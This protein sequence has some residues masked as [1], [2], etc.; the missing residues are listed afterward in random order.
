[1]ITLEISL[2]FT[3][4]ELGCELSSLFKGDILFLQIAVMLEMKN[5]NRSKRKHRI[6]EF[7]SQT[8]R[9]KTIQQFNNKNSR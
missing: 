8:R 6:P 4:A 5:K 2:R 9:K 7:F 1:M 3:A